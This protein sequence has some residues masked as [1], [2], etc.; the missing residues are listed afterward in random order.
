MWLI[1]QYIRVSKQLRDR[2]LLV[3]INADVQAIRDA[4]AARE[5][6]PDA[7]AVPKP[8][9]PEISD[10]I[11]RDL[12]QEAQSALSNKLILSA[13]LMAGAAFEYSLRQA[14]HRSGLSEGR[15]PVRQTIE[16]LKPFLP[17]GVAGELHALWDARNKIA[18]LRQEPSS[19][20][21]DPDTLID[22][23]KWGIS[24]LSNI[25]IPK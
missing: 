1:G 2:E 6:Q 9:S 21:L 14:A 8:A 13:L 22:G 5:N 10:P 7:A 24:L 20:A 23:F 17:S 3:G 25:G 19:T 11:A 12:F 18:H 16:Q 4:L 15:T